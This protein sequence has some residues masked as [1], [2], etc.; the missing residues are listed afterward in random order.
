MHFCS[1]CQNMYYIRI[2]G[3]NTNS[4]VYYCR[5]CGN[6]DSSITVDNVSVSKI[7]TKSGEQQFSH[8]INKYTKLDPTL[9]RINKVLCPNQEC[10]TNKH[11]TPREIIYIRYDAVNMK[12]IYLCSTCDTVW[13]AE[14]QNK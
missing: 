2:D 10:D 13:K 5:N 3:E 11:D 6:E 8:I 14:D 1:V 9:P 4:L 7:K 12:Y